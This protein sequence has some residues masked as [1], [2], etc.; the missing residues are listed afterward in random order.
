MLKN[1]AISSPIHTPPLTPSETSPLFH[2]FQWGEVQTI[3]ASE[4]SKF[5]VYF[6]AKNHRDYADKINISVVKI[7]QH[8]GDEMFSYLLSKTYGLTTPTSKL[9]TTDPTEMI[10]TAERLSQSTNTATAAGSQ[11]FMT[12][13][14]K[15]APKYLFMMTFIN[16]NGLDNIDNDDEKVRMFKE[17]DF[18]KMLGY[19]LPFD[20]LICN[21]DRFN[22]L[23]PDEYT[24]FGNI[25]LESDGEF[26]AIDNGINALGALEDYQDVPL[27]HYRD[28]LAALATA[29]TTGNQ[30]FID[31]IAEKIAGSIA[32]ECPKLKLN[33]TEH[34]HIASGIVAGILK[35]K[36][37]S[38]D[39]VRSVFDSIPATSG[40]TEAA[41]A[42]VLESL[43]V[44]HQH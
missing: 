15:I 34:A 5:G 38:E 10:M 25:V 36:E 22:V 14:S 33:K 37:M 41:L 9:V 43:Q 3:V 23:H 40:K 12:V 24:N 39:S 21:G 42:I 18:L 17:K 1:I 6:L 28:I 8:P 11:K 35:L 20:G 19:A 7:V 16:G 44:I 26:V 13:F 2:D 4:C 32:A 27:S 31:G 30:G 29:V